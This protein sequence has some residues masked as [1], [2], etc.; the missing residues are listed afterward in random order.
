MPSKANEMTIA[1]TFEEGPTWTDPH[2]DFLMDGIMRDDNMEA[3]R[4]QVMA[5][6][7]NDALIR[8]MET[9]KLTPCLTKS[10]KFMAKQ[11]MVMEGSTFS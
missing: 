5:V 7:W 3:S 9:G 8:N 10:L 1:L 4:V 2:V 6:R 11:G